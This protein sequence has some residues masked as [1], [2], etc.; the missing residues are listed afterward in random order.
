MVALRQDDVQGVDS[1]MS[2]D[3]AA[4]AAIGLLSGG[5]GTGVGERTMSTGI[6]LYCALN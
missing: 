6:R 5:S 1:G 4:G 3:G 2:F